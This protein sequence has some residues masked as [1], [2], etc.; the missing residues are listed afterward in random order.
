MAICLVT[1]SE[2]GLKCE[3]TTLQ[4]MRLPGTG[5]LPSNNLSPGSLPSPATISDTCFHCSQSGLWRQRDAN[6]FPAFQNT[7][8]IV[9]GQVH[10]LWRDKAHRTSPALLH[11][12]CGSLSLASSCPLVRVESSVKAMFLVLLG[13]WIFAVSLPSPGNPLHR[14]VLLAKAL[15]SPP[16]PSAVQSTWKCRRGKNRE[17]WPL[18][19]GPVG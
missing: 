5:L 18:H 7:K 6:S 3:P 17:G 16:D 9:L 10:Q 1:L 19:T 4:P 11:S 13:M 15:N 8:A 12:R 2:P 14:Y